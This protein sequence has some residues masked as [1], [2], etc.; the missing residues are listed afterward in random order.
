MT[1]WA[2]CRIKPISL[3]SFKKLLFVAKR[4]LERRMLAAASH[5]V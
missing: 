4:S 5:F 1:C 2:T 3:L